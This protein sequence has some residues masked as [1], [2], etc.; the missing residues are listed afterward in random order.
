MMDDDYRGMN[1]MLTF[2]S[3]VVG[4]YESNQ[5]QPKFVN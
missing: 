4:A 3:L 5:R 2:L 1:A